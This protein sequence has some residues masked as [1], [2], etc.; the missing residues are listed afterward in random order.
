MERVCCELILHDAPLLE[1]DDNWVWKLETNEEF[2]V[3]SLRRSWEKEN[4]LEL[5]Y[6]HWWNNWVPIKINFLGWWA[7]LN[8]L[9]NL[10]SKKDR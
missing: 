8:R 4:L 3:K 7:A 1:T 9:P 10:N 6:K 2:S 5:H